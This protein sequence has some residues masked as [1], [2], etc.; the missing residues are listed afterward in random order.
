MKTLNEFVTSIDNSEDLVIFEAAEIEAAQDLQQVYEMLFDKMFVVEEGLFSKIGN[1][2]SKM[3]DKSKELDDK[4]EAK[5]K[6]MSDAAKA[7]IDNVKKKAGDAWDKVKDT[8]TNAVAQ[9]DAG[10]QA[11][12][13]YWDDLSSKI[14]MKMSEIEAKV[15]TII[16]NGIAKGKE[17]IVK[18][19]SEADKAAAINT[20]IGGALMCLKNGMNSS[21]LIDIMSAAG[22]Q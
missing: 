4:I 9:V 21:D 5:K 7:A 16:T 12:K 6:A 19:F 8:Y 15:A 2:L 1:A 20:F 10:V 18:L 3:G 17:K 11:S 13:A 14:G 22:I